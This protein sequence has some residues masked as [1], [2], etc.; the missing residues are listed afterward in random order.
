MPR[1][2]VDSSRRTA[3]AFTRLR[4][5]GCP[6]Y[7]RIRKR[8]RLLT[9]LFFNIETMAQ[10]KLNILLTFWL[11]ALLQ[12]RAAGWSV[13]FV[14]GSNRSAI[15]VSIV[16][17]IKPTIYGCFDVFSKGH[18]ISVPSDWVTATTDVSDTI[19]IDYHESGVSI[20]NPRLD[21]FHVVAERA[22][23]S[24]T[25]AAG[26]PFVCRATGS[27]GDGRLVVDA[28]T[29]MTLVL[30]NLEL[31]SR[32]ASAICLRQKQKATIVMPEG[33]ASTLMDA[34]D[35]HPADSTETANGCLYA[36]G[37]LVFT[38]EGSLAVTGNYRH[39]IASGKNITVEGGRL[40][41]NDAVKNGIHCDKF[42]LQ[43]GGVSLTLSHDA[44]K[45]IKAKE[46]INIKGG[47]IEGEATGGLTIEG[48]DTSYSTLLKCDGT[49][50]VAGGTL[51]LDHHGDGGRCIS[52]DDDM[53]VTGGTLS[54]ECHGDGGSYV[55]G[56]GEPDY[57]TPKC[58]TVDDS[59]F[60]LSGAV[61]C[62]ST[63][64]GGK[65]IVAGKYLAI[66]EYE[67]Y[68][69][70]IRVE[71]KG[72]CIL[73]NEDEDLRS[74]CPKGIK[75]EKMLCVFGGNIAVATAGMGGEGVESN[76]TLLVFG[77]TLECNTFDDGINVADSIEIA[78]GQVYCNSVD[79]DG[80]DSNGSITV[81]GGIVA[82]VNQRK[83]NESFDA[84]KGRILLKG[85][86]VFGIGSGPV[87]PAEAF[88]P[89]FSSP[90]DVEEEWMMSQGL[91][92]TEGK[93]VCVQK[94][95]KVV[96]ALR[97]DNQAFRAFLTIMSPLFT[98][99]E[100]YTISEGDCPVSPRC[101]YFGGK[102]VVGGDACNTIPVTDE[103]FQIIK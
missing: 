83:P 28:D 101:S 47:Q 49:M 82:S 89:C 34:A 23:V 8:S 16:D 51:I 15:P 1:T 7:L 90:Y 29:T 56:S 70:T 30:D 87:V 18:A 17:S 4:Q 35:Y 55:N 74:G 79:N 57:Y 53:V 38:G 59:L 10:R 54:L 61:D 94:S 6:Q 88:C 9:F 96:L 60:I 48:G 12:T 31:S 3:W 11:L 86:T 100:P 43:G 37:S 97:N 69:P 93:Y 50:K 40:I 41:I 72:E 62:L 77:G 46:E 85:G 84:E 81:S 92:L 36:R 102:L 98:E 33:T 95:G 58:I 26:R 73:N 44:S 99:N 68:G 13:V 91:I 76:G 64:L 103:Y 5:T 39:G 65:G 19:V 78:G 24:I 21:L 67:A 2:E 20:F 32:T 66:G 63:G 45:G 71:T 27:S 25:S 14:K 75:A 52:V 22:A 42:T 80:I